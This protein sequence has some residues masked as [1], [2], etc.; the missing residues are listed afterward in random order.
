MHSFV[1]GNPKH[2]PVN[3]FVVALCQ[4]K[5]NHDI[6]G[7]RQINKSILIANLENAMSWSNL[8]TN[9]WHVGS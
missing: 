4:R 1:Q 3:C 6:E 2:S 9:S 8:D 7:N 5:I